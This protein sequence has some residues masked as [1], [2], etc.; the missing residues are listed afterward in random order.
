MGYCLFFEC[1]LPSVL[2]ARDKFCVG[3]RSNAT[4][5]FPDKARLLL[6]GWSH[7]K[8]YKQ[9]ISYWEDVYGYKMDTMRG[10]VLKEPHVTT[11]PSDATLTTSALTKVGDRQLSLC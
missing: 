2:V 3:E 9:K 8:F 11:L 6:S 4:K 7:S 5:V 1:M 10:S